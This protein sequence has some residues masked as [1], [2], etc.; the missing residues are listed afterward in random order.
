MGWVGLG[1]VGSGGVGWGRVGSGGVGS[2][3]RH[4]C[5]IFSSTVYLVNSP[6]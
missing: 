1:R 5:H 2:F 4:S 3:F 6:R